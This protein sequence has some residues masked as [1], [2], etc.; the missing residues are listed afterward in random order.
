M[1][2]DPYIHN[3]YISDLMLYL[4]T[5]VGLTRKLFIMIHLKTMERN[6]I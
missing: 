1:A 3:H 4:H 6:N 5:Y 2:L